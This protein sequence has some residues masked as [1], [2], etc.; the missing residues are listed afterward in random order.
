MG[1]VQCWG[2]IL[3]CVNHTDSELGDRVSRRFA[4]GSG[5]IVTLAIVT[6]W[7]LVKGDYQ[8]DTIFVVVMPKIT[9][10]ALDA[11]LRKLGHS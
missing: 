7:C 1:K 5:C 2:P 11:I 8:F 6:R 4:G 3:C 10:V 9:W